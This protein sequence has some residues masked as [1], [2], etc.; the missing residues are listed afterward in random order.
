MI[1]KPEIKKIGI[2][3]AQSGG[4]HKRMISQQIFENPNNLLH[5]S[6]NQGVIP[7]SKSPV[8]DTS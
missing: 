5:S 2:P 3:L 6:F 4:H 8:L 1:F 7:K